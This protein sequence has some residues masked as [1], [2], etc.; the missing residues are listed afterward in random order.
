MKQCITIKRCHA[1]SVL[2]NPSKYLFTQKWEGHILLLFYSGLISSFQITL[3]AEEEPSTTPF[4][5]LALLL[6]LLP[7]LFTL[8][9]LLV[10][11]AERSHKNTECNP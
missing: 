6:L 1:S 4:V 8:W 9:K 3:S 11:F 2:L 5:L 10:L 7:L